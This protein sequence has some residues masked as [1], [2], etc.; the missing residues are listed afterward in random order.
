AQERFRTDL[1]RY[2]RQ[3]RCTF[4]VVRTRCMVPRREILAVC[5]LSCL[6]SWPE[7][8]RAQNSGNNLWFVRG[9]MTS[10]FI[11]HTNP[12]ALR[13]TGA[14][15]PVHLAPNIT[16]EAGRR[17]DGTSAWHR[18]YGTPSYGLGIALVQL[19]DAGRNGHP[20]E[21]YGFFSWPFARLSD[22]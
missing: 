4:A 15:E 21:T 12:F 8:A 16:L 3:P 17:T 10:A 5:L 6:L 2:R 18:L 11:L 1:V 22:R 19:P 14:S 20:I 7:A 9:G 13:A